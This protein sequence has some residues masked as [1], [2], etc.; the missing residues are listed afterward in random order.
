MF[1][2]IVEEV[3]NV[4]AAGQRMRIQ[5]RRVLEDIEEG[6]S[7]AVNGVCLTATKIES[8]GFWCDLSP[9]TL[10]RTNLGALREGS[11]VNL[12]RPAAIGDRLSGHIVQGHVDGTAG[13]VLLEPLADG[14]WWLKARIPP[15]LDRYLIHKGSVTLDGVS[16]TVASLENGVLG[17]AIIPHTYEHTILHSYRPGAE[18]NVEV[19]LIGKYIEKLYPGLRKARPT[20]G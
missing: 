14:N 4:A 2:G 15:E 20:V 13:F 10:A 7:I 12:E 5:C 18:I 17:V 6:A 3:G 16:L 1:T 19:D 8:D 9:E 11:L